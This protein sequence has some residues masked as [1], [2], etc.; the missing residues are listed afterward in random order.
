MA[1]NTA[2]DGGTRPSAG[3]P[4]IASY[5]SYR[6]AER[7]IEL[8]A[9]AGFPVERTAI[10]GR[11]LEAVEDVRG[12]VDRTQSALRG[13]AVGGASG[14]LFGWLFGLL[15]AVD[16]LIAGVLLALYGFALGAVV[17]ALLGIALAFAEGGRRHFSSLGHIRA[18]RYEVEVD[19]DE[20]DRAARLLAGARG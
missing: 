5:R 12:P 19:G 6:D 11:D 15:G 18:G 9:E 2:S 3:R 13:V 1:G 8:L 17:G 16:P 4:V 14:A 20:A 10:V 7:A